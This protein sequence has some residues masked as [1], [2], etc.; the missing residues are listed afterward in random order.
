LYAGGADGAVR[1]ISEASGLAY[2]DGNGPI[3]AH[4]PSANRSD[5]SFPSRNELPVRTF[6]IPRPLVVHFLY[7]A[8]AEMRHLFD[9]TKRTVEDEAYFQALL[10]ADLLLPDGIALALSNYRFRHPEKNPFVT[11]F[12]YGK[13]A[14]KSLSTLNGTDFLPRVLTELRDRYA[15]RVSAYLYGTRRE[16]VERAAAKVESEFG[17]PCGFQD[18]FSPFDFEKFQAFPGEKKILLVGMG[19]PKQE[20][21][22]AENLA[23]LS[24]AA[25]VFSVGGLFDFWGGGERRAPEFV[26]NVRG[27]WIWRLVTNPKKNF[28][29]VWTSLKFFP[30]FF[31]GF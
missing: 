24:D 8:N 14:D 12:R 30:R 1:G 2:R 16:I 13:N 10:D 19:T 20:L 5:R 11:L 4:G 15:D 18:G 27:E 25:A 9:P 17:I 29:K 21:W 7:F 3:L 28:K 23:N 26:R 22:V 6:E 31:S